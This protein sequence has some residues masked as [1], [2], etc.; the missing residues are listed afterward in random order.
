MTGSNA[1]I[2]IETLSVENEKAYANRKTE[3]SFT[4]TFLVKSFN[5][6]LSTLTLEVLDN[7]QV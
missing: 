5:V 7:N 1:D 4:S 6:C 2:S 3:R